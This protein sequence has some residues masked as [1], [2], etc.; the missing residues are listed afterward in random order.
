MQ[1]P[2]P[3]AAGSRG[4]VFPLYPVARAAGVRS[5]TL[6]AGVDLGGAADQCG[7]RL[8]ELAVASGT[9]VH[10]GLDG[11]GAEAPVLLF[12]KG[13]GRQTSPPSQCFTRCHGHPGGDAHL[14]ACG[15]RE[16]VLVNVRVYRDRKLRGWVAARHTTIL[17]Q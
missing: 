9:V 17:L 13:D 15:R 16:D 2:S 5:W 3:Y 12:P 7:V 11:F 4:W 6:D 10:E 8:L 1:I 14:V